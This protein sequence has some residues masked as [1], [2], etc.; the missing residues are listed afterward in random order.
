MGT[1]RLSPKFALALALSLTGCA[2][3]GDERGADLAR[4]RDALATSWT[5]TV[6]FRA[7]GTNEGSVGD[8][9]DELRRQL[10]AGGLGA[11]TLLSSIS[12]P[13][14]DAAAVYASGYLY[15]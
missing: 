9:N 1:V 12:N 3:A 13:R 5:Q 7:L 6:D 10:P 14:S 4:A 11:W 8:D 15:L 2:P